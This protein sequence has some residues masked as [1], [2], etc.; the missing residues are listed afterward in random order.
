MCMLCVGN[1]ANRIVECAELLRFTRCD[2]KRHTGTSIARR[3]SY[4]HTEERVEEFVDE[5]LPVWQIT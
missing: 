3:V 5:V 1:V 2:H 4:S